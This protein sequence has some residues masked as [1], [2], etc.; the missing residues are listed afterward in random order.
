MGVKDTA[1]N[2]LRGTSIE[3]GTAR[4]LAKGD[5]LI[6]PNGVPH[7]F[8]EVQA[9]VPLLHGQGHGRRGRPAHDDRRTP[10]RRGAP[11]PG[12]LEA[13]G[14]VRQRSRVGHGARGL[15]PGRHGVGVPAARPCALARLSLERG[16]PR[17]HLRSP[18]G[19][20]PGAGAVERA[21]SDPEGAA[22]RPHRQRR[23]PRRGRQGV[24][25]LSR[26]DAD[27][28][29]MRMLY[30]Y[31]QAAFPYAAARRREPPPRPATRRSSS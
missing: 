18:P 13:L 29:F 15:Q 6:V 8:T 19:S 31:P 28:L 26:L 10:A 5:V 2:E 4:R 22:V 24:L 25:L 16:R 20:L 14:A 12:A 17:R 27:A 3:G 7:Q 1:P 23:Q 9:P 30:K 11:A 21:R